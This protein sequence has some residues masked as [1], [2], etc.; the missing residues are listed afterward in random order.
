M[1]EKKKNTAGRKPARA[2]KPEAAKKVSAAG[3]PEK[4]AGKKR[5]ITEISRKWYLVDA[6][7][8]ILGRLATRVAA[9]LRGKHK[10]EFSPHMDNGDFVIV[11]NARGVRVTGNKLQDKSYFS[12][13]G[14]NGGDRLEKMDHLMVRK[15]QDVIYHAVAGMIPKNKLGARVIGKLKVYADGQHPH[16]A[17]KPEVLN[18]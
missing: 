4:A 1:A 6:N 7:D 16:S 9:I 5:K 18:I 14:Y 15:P 2:K 12:H 8:R 17:Q 13:S 10:P 11:I 3:R